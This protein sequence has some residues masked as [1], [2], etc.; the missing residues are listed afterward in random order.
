MALGTLRVYTVGVPYLALSLH[1]SL[2]RAE[3]LGAAPYLV[4]DV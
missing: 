3:A 1:L 4:G 2:D